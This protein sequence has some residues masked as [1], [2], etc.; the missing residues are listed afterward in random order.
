MALVALVAD[1]TRAHL[2]VLVLS[3]AQEEFTAHPEGPPEASSQSTQQS[4][5][6]L[7]DLRK[8]ISAA[9]SRSSP[10]VAHQ[11]IDIDVALMHIDSDGD[12]VITRAE[13]SARL[14]PGL[15]NEANL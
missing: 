1:T 13:V 15:T 9:V 3:P 8:Q 11:D 2:S 4:T 6:P 14:P 10:G 7:A 12:G 5:Q